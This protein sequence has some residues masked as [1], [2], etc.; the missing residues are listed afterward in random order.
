MHQDTTGYQQPAGGPEKQDSGEIP[1]ILVGICSC[2]AYRDKRDAG[3]ESWLTRPAAGV[4]T[5][6]FIGGGTTTDD[7]PDM[8]VLD[9]DD[10]Y[11]HLPEKVLAFFARALAT[12]DFEWLFKCD[13]DTYVA[14]E[15]LDQLIRPGYEM[16]G[17][18]FI[19]TRGAP[20]GGAGYLLSRRVVELLVN[21]PSLPS[22]GAEDMII[23]QA[24]AR[25]EV[26]ALATDT[27]RW[28]ASDHPMPDN[29]LVTAH[30]CS[31]ARLKAIHSFLHDSPV[32]RFKGAH[33]HWVD[34][35]HL[36][37]SGFF[38]RVASRCCGTWREDE[39][40]AITLGWFDWPEETLEFDGL[41]HSNSQTRIVAC[42]DPRFHAALRSIHDVP[43][44]DLRPARHEARLLYFCPVGAAAMDTWL[45]TAEAF[46][47]AGAEIRLVAY[48]SEPVSHPGFEIQG[49]VKGGKWW[50]AADLIAPDDVA[51]F[52]YLF[53][54]DDD[55]R[56][57]SFDPRAFA[58]IM[59]VNRLDVAQPA[60]V[61]SHRLSH[62]ITA[63]VAL[64]DFK[65]D[66]HR[67]VGRLTNFA[68]VMVPVFSRK[69]WRDFHPFI[70]R[71]NVSAWGYDYFPFDRRGIVDVMTVE[72]T[73]PVSSGGLHSMEDLHTYVGQHG[74]LQYP[75][76]AS[77]YLF[78]EK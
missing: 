36:Y 63:P 43:Y 48:G 52:D 4:E 17:N 10:S 65:L 70:S 72:H 30:W 51:D 40:R 56:L 46:K 7:E 12:S 19:D 31:P 50:M 34:E 28:D 76:L 73:R 24:A 33:R 57:E 22:T 55:M 29:A 6:F 62:P 14:L 64:P 45:P 61:S 47:R 78:G 2:A 20:S 18:V 5:L 53:L 11:D 44:L 13:D 32:R 3:R 35:I 60:I 77:G 16:V 15:R 74:I 27:L 49:P 54:W 23:G 38:R 66:G 9:C 39:S 21:D 41:R 8:V 67:A 58:E 69:A 68:E 42:G 1:K 75:P 37:G 71:A 26:A 25:H 59:R